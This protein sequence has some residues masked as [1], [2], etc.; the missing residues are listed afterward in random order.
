MSFIRRHT[1]IALVALSCIALGAGAGA[2]ASAGAATNSA[3]TNPHHL[4]LHGLRRFAARAVHGTIVVATP[5]GFRTITFDRGQVDAVN[6]RRLTITEGTKKM[7]Y[8]AV[9]LTIPASARVRDN[10]QPTTL[11]AVKPGQ[12]VIV[13]E[14]PKRTFVMAHDPR[15][16]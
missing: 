3:T 12:R 5:D 9:T 2:I 4:R 6:G 15:Q 8:K 1:R 7:S 13:V 10:G 11:S 16:G 14:A